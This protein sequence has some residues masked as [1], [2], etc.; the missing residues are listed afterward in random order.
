[1]K[2]LQKNNKTISVFNKYNLWKS[3]AIIEGELAKAQSQVGLI[4]KKVANNILKNSKLTNNDIKKIEA[5]YKITKRL[6]LSIVREISKK[7]DENSSGFVHWG[8]TTRNILDA[9]RNIII[10]DAHR[11]ILKELS[12][13]INKLSVLS[14]K[15]AETPMLG[16]TMGQNAI[17]IS[18][19]FK[20][21]GWIESL[22]RLDKKF[23][24]A[25]K[26]IFTLN[27]G[28]AVG[29]MH[30]F[31]GKGEQLTKQLSKNLGFNNSL[32]PN[33][34]SIE[35]SIDYL[36][37][38][39]FQGIVIGKITNEIYALMTQSINEV[40]EIKTKGQIG[41]STMPHKVNPFIILDVIRE[42][43]LLRGKASI[44]IE[45]GFPLHEG[46]S[47]Y[48]N[49]VDHL[50][51]E[52]VPISLN[53]LENFNKLFENLNINSDQ[54]S[55]NL[56]SEKD[57]IA[58]ENLMYK[59]AKHI[60]RQ[61]AHDIIHRTIEKSVKKS[62]NIKDNLIKEKIISYYFSSSEIEKILDPLKYIGESKK[63]SLKLSRIAKKYSSD[64]KKRASKKDLGVTK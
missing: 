48:D 58:S 9:G 47:R 63:I 8:G 11:L 41:S 35:N 7:C 51:K 50:I 18:F 44:S 17:P 61:K 1:M 13:S 12:L 33:R 40:S 45:S 38:L 46:D 19:G 10:R 25:E 64:I 5:S 16:R 27:F 22:I 26:S 28:G 24:D 14:K 39:S 21:A 32:V 62:L 60:G 36:L 56:I 3:Y 53:L 49:V 34:T 20:V 37:S 30:G 31:E 54:M 15:Y 23:K 43:A 52:T 42:A 6:I 57:Y 55:K 4:P 29:A 2:S 59:L